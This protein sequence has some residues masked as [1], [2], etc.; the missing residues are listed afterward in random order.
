M[1]VVHARCAGLDVHQRTVVACMRW[2]REGE[3]HYQHRT[4]PTT[5]AGLGALR[6]WLLSEGC[7]HVGMEATGVY[8]K[9]VWHELEGHFGL[10]LA[11]AQRLR[12]VPGRKSDVGDARWIADLLACGLIA[13]S[14]VPPLA[15]QQLRDLTRTRTQMKRELTRHTQRITKALEDAQIKLPSVVS[16]V[17]GATGRK[18]L[19]AL[20]A[21]ETDGEKLG[22]LRHVR[23]KA[24][25]EEFVA[26]L[27]GQ[28]NEHHRFLLGL[29]LQQIEHLERAI[30]E[31]EERIAKASLPFRPQLDRLITIP[32]VKDTAACVMLAEHGPDMSVFPTAAHLRSWTG[33]CP[34][35]H[36]SAGKKRSTRLRAGNPWLRTV[37]V[38]AAWAATRARGS[39]LSAQYYRI[40]ARRG[41]QKAI[42][43]VAASI[44][45]CAHSMLL[46]DQP[47]QDWRA[48]RE[49][50]PTH[51]A[52]TAKRLVARLKDLGYRVD[53][54]AAA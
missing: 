46:R 4:F 14:F 52:R 13:G 49:L 2:Q 33:L 23:L 37:L 39:A 36:E 7:T 51:R 48:T 45:T 18:V 28:L 17:L 16:Q 30:S 40:K 29:H 3:T 24:S 19:K 11:N 21:G 43:A 20:I 27:Q 8:W 53:L 26:A 32:G 34:G 41:P 6:E 5:T 31:L 22:S 25:R 15:I 9:P 42:I 12:H 47:Y 10:I 54:K 35:Q 38:Q 44:L 50:S 1:E